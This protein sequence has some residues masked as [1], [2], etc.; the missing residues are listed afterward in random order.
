MFTTIGVLSALVERSRSG[1]GQQVDV[2]MLDCQ[3]ALMENAIVRY[4]STGEVPGP[5]GFRHPLSTPHQAF[6]ASD[7]WIVVAN[8]KD[9]PLFCGVVGCDELAL[10][11]RLQT[12]EGQTRHCAELEVLGDICLVG[13]VNDVAEVVADPQV[14]ARGMLVDLPTWTGGALRVANTPVRLSRTP[15]GATRGAP[16]PGADTLEV[17]AKEAGLSQEAIQQLL[18]RGLVR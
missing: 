5:V 13:P 2:A 12:N 11:E 1:L 18:S 7:G 4:T 15:G 8:V 9:W 17:L 10:D 6:P 16:A 14:D 3:V